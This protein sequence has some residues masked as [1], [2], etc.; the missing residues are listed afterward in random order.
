[1]SIIKKIIGV[2]FVFLIGF[3]V[4]YSIYLIGYYQERKKSD[5]IAKHRYVV[6]GKIIKTG[7]M[8]GSYAVAE[9]FAG[10][11]RF[12]VKENSP[13]E[14]IL[15]GQWFQIE[16]DSTNPDVSKILFEYP[17]FRK[18]DIIDSTNGVI[19]QHD[20]FRIRFKYIIDGTIYKKFQGVDHRQQIEDGQR[21]QV[22]Y[23][24]VN[25]FIALLKLPYIKTIEW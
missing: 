9:Y 17:L 15:K 19:I 18:G 6:A 13:A 5:Q 12:T 22:N 16:Y 14:D 7:S 24:K 4:F 3:G 23:L 21:F 1:M 25:P 10:L 20:R 11:S 2:F 8:K